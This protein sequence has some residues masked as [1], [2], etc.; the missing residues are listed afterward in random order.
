MLGDAVSYPIKTFDNVFAAVN[1]L[2]WPAI[3]TLICGLLNVALMIPLLKYTPWGLYAVAG[4][5]TFLLAGKDLFFKIPYL[6]RIAGCN[7]RTMWGYIF[8]YAVAAVA[9]VGISMLTKYF[10]PV[11]NWIVLIIDAVIT[12][13]L[14][15]SVNLFII[16][17]KNSRKS[18]LHKVKSAL[19]RF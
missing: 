8:R 10:I 13:I 6:S 18:V 17:D 11:S 4:T 9:I 2:R 3:A 15:L 14:G 1:K 16:F 19:V 12:S 5:S 7:V